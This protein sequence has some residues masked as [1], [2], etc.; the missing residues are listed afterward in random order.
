[1]SQCSV[2]MIGLPLALLSLLLPPTVAPAATPTEPDLSLRVVFVGDVMLDGG[3]GHLVANGGDPFL[4]L[5]ALLKDADLTLANLE[6]AITSS[7]EVLRKDYTFKGPK[8][9]LPLLTRYFSAVSLANNHALDWG[10]EGFLGELELLDKAKL[11]HFG[12]GR[13]TRAAHEPWV[14][15]R[16]GRRV[17]ILG[18]S[19]FG[20]PTFTPSATS[21][22]VA[23]LIESSIIADITAARIEHHADLVILFLHWGEE[24]EPAPT[25]AQRELAHRLIDAGADAIVGGHPHVIQPLEW[26]KERPILYSLGNFVFDYFPKDPPV[27]RGWVARLIFNR[28]AATKVETFEVEMD[29]QGVPHLAAK[30]AR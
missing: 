14:V 22:G 25:A 3:P 2:T 20:G 13:N 8:S 30:P 11:A 10:K 9:A 17:A 6:C 24:L 12:A 19:A 27:W 4:P 23:L 18:A 21:P 16:Q 5:S 28:A 26:Y 15:E 1:V 7:G 29:P